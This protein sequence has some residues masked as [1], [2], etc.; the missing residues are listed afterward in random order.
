MRFKSDYDEETGRTV[1]RTMIRFSFSFFLFNMTSRA[2]IERSK[3][4][5]L[6]ENNIYVVWRVARS[7]VRQMIQ[8]ESVFVL[9]QSR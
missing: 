6:L 5:H 7:P 4:Q 1:R 2:T 8:R 3:L 9:A